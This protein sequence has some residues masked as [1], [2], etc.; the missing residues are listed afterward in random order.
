[1]PKFHRVYGLL[2]VLVLIATATMRASAQSG[3]LNDADPLLRDAK[4][5]AAEYRVD[6]PEAIR[7][8]KLQVSAGDL[9][10]K[11]RA[12]EQDIFAGLWI[13]HAPQFRVI[14]QFI[15][16]GEETIRPYIVNGPLAN[17]VEVRPAHVTL[18]KLEADQKVALRAIRAVGV[19]VDSGLNV[20]QNRVE[21]YVTDHARLDTALQ[22]ASLQ[23]PET[24][25]VITV[26]HLS[27][28]TSDI[29]G[30]LAITG[31]TT[32]FAAINP[33]VSAYILTAGHCSDTQSYAGQNLALV[34]Q[35][36]YYSYDIQWHSPAPFGLS[37]LI[38]D[39]WGTRPIRAAKGRDAQ[40]IGDYVCHY[41]KTTGYGCGNIYDKN[42]APSWVQWANP[43]FI[44]VRTSGPTLSQ[45]GDSGG[46]W[47]YGNTAFGIMSGQWG[48]WAPYDGIYMAVN[49]LNDFGLQILTCCY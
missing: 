42:I 15:R 33:Q 19:P 49:Y 20:F 35:A 17:I 30:G 44:R 45:P 6:L 38:F 4:Q 48:Y 29:Y 13:Q 5:Y 37:N 23:L 3:P 18:A 25:Q 1:M 39:G 46:P 12:K 36:Q 2:V 8:L 26:P 9:E 11:L 7:R 32:G 10:V 22:V 14:V 47:F 43:T 31:C 24:V 40:A 16:D 34:G 41:G 27:T 21:V 28:P